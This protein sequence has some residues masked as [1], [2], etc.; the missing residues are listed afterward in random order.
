MC[1]VIITYMNMKHVT[2]I[3]EQ[4][5]PC[6]ALLYKLR[7]MKGF[8]LYFMEQM[9]RAD[10]GRNVCV[11]SRIFLTEM[12]VKQAHVSFTTYVIS[13]NWDILIWEW[14]SQHCGYY[15]ET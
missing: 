8:L 1:A 5:L 6:T 11:W 10:Y 4:V 12:R 13:Y 3:P 7:K 9:N 14:G 15:E 2:N